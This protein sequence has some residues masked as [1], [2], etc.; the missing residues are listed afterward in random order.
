MVAA[1]AA[2]TQ[3]NSASF[4]PSRLCVKSSNLEGLINM[5]DIAKTT[6]ESTPPTIY[7]K[8]YTP[9]AYLV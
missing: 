7:L 2:P 4:A 8:D 3:K 6:P 1:R 5:A 9:P